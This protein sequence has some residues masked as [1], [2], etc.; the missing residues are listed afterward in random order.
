VVCPAAPGGP[1]T[2]IE[3]CNSFIS[4]GISSRLSKKWA[5]QVG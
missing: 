5:E 3:I 2:A 4:M 1:F